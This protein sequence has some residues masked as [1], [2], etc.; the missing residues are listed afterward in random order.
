MLEFCGIIFLRGFCDFGKLLFCFY[1]YL[2]VGGT[3]LLTEV[4]SLCPFGTS[5]LTT[6]KKI[7]YDSSVNSIVK[8]DFF[9][10]WIP[11]F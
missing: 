6:V 2:W 3:R 9:E 1:F 8:G 7:F 4:S 10:N 5:I 11:L